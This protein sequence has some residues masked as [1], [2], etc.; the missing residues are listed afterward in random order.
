MPSSIVLPAGSAAPFAIARDEIAWAGIPQDVG[1]CP[2]NYLYV[3]NL[4]AFHPQPVWK[5][6]PC[7][8]ISDVR[9]SAKWVVWAAGVPPAGI[10]WARNLVTGRVSKVAKQPYLL[11]NHPCSP[12]S[13]VPPVAFS[14][15]GSTVVWSHFR[16]T[17]YGD[18]MASAI[19]LRTLPRGQV[20]TL[21]STNAYCEMQIDPDFAGGR[22]VWLTA[23]WPQDVPVN[24]SPPR[25]CEGTVQTTVLTMK[26]GQPPIS[27]TTDGTVHNV[28]TNGQ[29]ITWEDTAASSPGC[30]CS[31][32]VLLD[33]RTRHR[34]I[35]DRTVTASV[36]TPSVLSW[37]SQTASGN[38]VRAENLKTSQ[39]T[40]LSSS[41]GAATR[42]FIR[43]LGWGWGARVV[44]EV[45]HVY[46]AK[47]A[48]AQ[49]E[50][51]VVPST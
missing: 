19:R 12:Q 39:E 32:L 17:S 25:Q 24:S 51:K 10:I 9:M 46:G 22:V 37:I 7:A 38:S 47:G 42:R 41:G 27:L 31:G 29:F 4:R 40:Q 6:P 33:T 49:V 48:R 35:L 15:D 44:W 20:R 13:C 45:D 1:V 8:V 26:L 28:Q 30:V 34:V 23:G 36:L 16:F 11:A 50:M 43:A 5:A 21:Y 3:A 18:L 14:L 2:R